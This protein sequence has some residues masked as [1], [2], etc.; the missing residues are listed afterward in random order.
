M[1]EKI[2][3]VENFLTHY[4]NIYHKCLLHSKPSGEF[5]FISGTKSFSNKKFSYWIKK[6]SFGNVYSYVKQIENNIKTIEQFCKDYPK[7]IKQLKLKPKTAG[8]GSVFHNNTEYG[9]DID[10][11][12]KVID[13]INTIKKNIKQSYQVK[14]FFEKCVENGNVIISYGNKNNYAYIYNDDKLKNVM[15]KIFKNEIKS[16][17]ENEDYDGA[18]EYCKSVADSKIKPLIEMVEK[19]GIDI[20]RYSVSSADGSYYELEQ[21]KKY[22]L[23]KWIKDVSDIL[24]YKEDFP[25]QMKRKWTFIVGPTNSGKTHEAMRILTAGNSGTYLAPLR[26][27][28]LEGYETLIENGFDAGMITGEEV[29]NQ[30]ALFTS[31]TI[32]MTN[33]SRVVDVAIIDEVQMLTDTRRG[34]AWTAAICGCPAKHMVLVG[35]PECL[36]TVMSLLNTI[37]ETDI[38]V[39]HLERKNELEFCGK[40]DLEDTVAGDA[41]VSFTRRDILAIRNRLQELGKSVAVIYGGLSPEVRRTEAKRFRDGEV[42]ILV[43]SD[44]IGMGLNLP[45]RRIIFHNDKKYDGNETR[46]LN[47][48][49]VKQIAGRAGRYGLHEKGYVA[50]CS[51]NYTH[52]IKSGLLRNDILNTKPMIAPSSW[53][54]ETINSLGMNDSIS[55]ALYVFVDSFEKNLQTIPADMSDIM[56]VA[57]V[58]DY[59][60]NI[61]FDLKTQYINVPCDKHNVYILAGWCS[62]HNANKTVKFSKVDI[63]QTFDELQKLESFVRTADMYMWLARRFPEIYVDVDEAKNNRM[64]ANEKIISILEKKAEKQCKKCGKILPVLSKHKFCEDCHKKRMPHEYINFL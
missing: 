56:E 44:A 1:D 60:Q 7:N 14:V 49:E 29:H 5:I 47:S 39:I 48:L 37:G 25:I 46:F 31:C 6:D 32:E 50:V 3:T 27:L 30:S 18:A 51:Q 13:I 19:N 15:I 33:F 21:L 22:I 9:I 26:L 23:S 53:H 40:I 57:N 55:A 11:I 4:R 10:V 24:R 38:E 41:I 2:K 16:F 12:H 45:I 35:S 62:R 54:L 20:T 34:W 63:Q 17:I 59:D 8:Q 43:A 42:D 58:L 61:R 28:A 64:N 36:D 52:T